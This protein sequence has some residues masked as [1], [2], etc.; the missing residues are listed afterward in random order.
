MRRLAATLGALFAASA[1]RAD[2]VSDFYAGKT[3]TLAISGSAGGGYDVL[4]RAVARFLGRHIPGNPAV[5]VKN[6]PGAG[7]LLLMNQTYN[8]APRDGTWLA[9]AQNN[10]PFEPLY[11]TKEAEYDAR[12][13][14]YVGS[15]S[16]EVALFAVMAGRGVRDI[17]DARAKAINVG[18][19]GR[20]STPSFYARL[21]NETLGTKQ[22]IIVGY[23]GQ[24]DGL[25]A[26]ERGEVDGYPSAFYN[27]LMSTRPTWIAD[28]VVR[29]I[30]QFGSAKEP[31][32]ADTPWAT[33]LAANADDRALVEAGSAPLG[34]G[35]PYLMGPGVPAD[36]VAAMRR[37]FADVMRDPDFQ[38]ENRR[39]QLGANKPQSAEELMAGVEKAYAAA[40]GV[41]ARLRQL[42]H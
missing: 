13:F 35:R 8:T 1:A 21:A 42:L 20:N 9:S 16:A 17:A 11:G 14:N 12:K 33:E 32:I 18:S 30:V 25:L 4:G 22:N 23:P 29:L 31:A 37:A 6:V 5:V 2:A 27:S 38:A 26:M 39:A 28:G 3:V 10:T 41:I 40:P 36:R 15:P 7:G 24:N 19:S 34:V